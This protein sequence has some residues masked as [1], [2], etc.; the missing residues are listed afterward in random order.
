MLGEGSVD[1][2]AMI[3][4]LEGAGYQGWYVLEQDLM[5]TDGEPEGEGPMADVRRCLAYV[6]SALSGTGSA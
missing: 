6:E 4:A 1:V 2:R 3:D 5:L